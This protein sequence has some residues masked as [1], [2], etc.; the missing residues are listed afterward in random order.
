MTDFSQNHEQESATA[1]FP[2]HR[3][4]RILP[5]QRLLIRKECSCHELAEAYLAAAESSSLNAYVLLT[6]KE[7]FEAAARTDRHI[8]AGVPLS[9][10]EGI[11]LALKDNIS[12]DG[13]PTTC[14]STMLEKYTPIYD[15]TAW[16]LLKEQNTL[17]LG[18]ANMDEFAMGSTCETSSFGGALNPYGENRVPG[19]S[20]GG[21]AAAVAA[22]LAAYSLGTDTGGSI[23][24]PASF[25]GLVG[26]KPTYGAVSRYGLIAHASS[27]DQIGPITASAM[28]AAIV[29]DAIAKP[30]P[31]D[32]TCT[33]SRN[34]AVKQ[35]GVSLKGKRIGIL[36]EGFQGSREE[37]RETVLKAAHTFEELGAV[38]EECS[39][40][41][42]PES[43]QI[44]Y[45]L[46]C[47][48]A[49]SNLGRYDGIRYG[50]TPSA[51]QN[52]EDD[53]WRERI[54][55][56]RSEGFGREVKRRI[57]LGTFV[58]S[59]GYYD[60]FYRKAQV[61]RR[62]L[63]QEL[64]A[65]LEDFDCLLLPTTATAAFPAGTLGSDAVEN[66][67]ADFCT[68]A[69]NCAGLPALSFPCGMTAE[70]LPIG[71]QLLGRPFEDPFLLN[72]LWQY[73]EA[74]P[75][76]PEPTG[77]AEKTAGGVALGTYGL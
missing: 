44:Y 27:F 5:L 29:L 52:A 65:A 50:H 35:L 48:E 43:L 69:A 75:S 6:P 41:L 28:D 63:S 34:S 74:V 62:A 38:V 73:E 10:L 64:H 45:V 23:R 58:L 37:I 4:D 71:A 68:V 40:P 66:F 2:S 16:K 14:C 42:L 39:V 1:A 59:A 70:G 46:A 61:L 20:S 77:F 12:T 15:A 76:I 13:I 21:S 22:G 9:P 24:Q 26:L 32:P 54:L 17:L 18:K 49:S 57:L 67:E 55:R 8:R 53:D 3:R 51:I 72:L 56:A 31:M 11:P 30:D 60:A 19:G 7:A 25:C 33:G 36:Q 47:A